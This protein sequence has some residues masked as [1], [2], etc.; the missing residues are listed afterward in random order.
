MIGIN[1]NSLPYQR[2]ISYQMIIEDYT[3]KQIVQELQVNP[4]IIKD[5]F[6]AEGL[7]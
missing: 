6:K 4:N 2:K 3:P 1:V 5:H 7:I